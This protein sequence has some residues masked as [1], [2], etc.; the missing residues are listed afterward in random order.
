ML[1]FDPTQPEHS[2]FEIQNEQ[3]TNEKAKKKKGEVNKLKEPD[4]EP[5]P[6]VSKSVFYEVTENLKDVFQEKSAFSFL[7]N[8]SEQKSGKKN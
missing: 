2:I 6:E 1:R 5:I 7:N 8:E 4:V 3:V